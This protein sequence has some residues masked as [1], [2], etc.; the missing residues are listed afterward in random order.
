[1]EKQATP[2]SEV[3][4][5]AYNLV[6][7]DRQSSYGH[8]LDDYSTV[9]EIYKSLTGIDLT[10]Y[11]AVLFMVSVKLARL[12][13]NMH[14]GSLHHDSLV[15]TLGYVTLL[16]MIKEAQDVF[17]E[18]SEGRSASTHRAQANETGGDREEARSE[19]VQGIRGGVQRR[20]NFIS[21]Y[22]SRA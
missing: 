6:N 5:E 15:D 11:E 21:R 20:R 10:V 4:L 14:G 8:P 18:R 13:T 12:K 19:A 22:F 17:S 2:G 7:Q 3:L 9:V 16:S 1:M